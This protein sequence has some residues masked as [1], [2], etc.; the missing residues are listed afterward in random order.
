MEIPDL[1]RI[2]P[3]VKSGGCECV[4]DLPRA[5]A[6]GQAWLRKISNSAAMADCQ[7]T[8]SVGL[9]QESPHGQLKEA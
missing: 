6:I 5:L 3:D 7:N 8:S 2:E 9:R 1:V 4:G